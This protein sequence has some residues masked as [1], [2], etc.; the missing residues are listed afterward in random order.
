MN[1]DISRFVEKLER[2]NAVGYEADSGITRLALTD[3]DFKAREI[4]LNYLETLGLEV[5]LD[6]VGNIIARKNGTDASLPSVLVGS[7]L[8]TVPGGGAYDGT[9]GV[10]AA[11][12]AVEMLIDNRVEHEHPI[13]IIVFSIEESSRF[14]ISTVGSKIIT[15]RLKLEELQFYKDKQGQSIYDALSERGLMRQKM[16]LVTPETVKAFVELHIEQGPILERKNRDVGIVEAIAAP[17]RMRIKL[18]GEEAHSGSC[19]MDMRRDALTT[20][21]KIIIEV[22]KKGREESQYK[23]VATVGNC[24][25]YPGAMNVVPGQAVISIDIRGVDTHS[26]LRTFNYITEQTKC[27]CDRENTDYT[28]EIISQE[29]P[30]ILDKEVQYKIQQECESLGLSYEFMLSGAGH[31]TMN[32][33]KIVPSALIFI[34]CIK[35]ISHNKNEAVNQHDLENGLKILYK[36]LARLAKKNA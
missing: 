4:V 13:E 35:G 18:I 3:A 7:H 19:P 2:V 16:S 33:A 21:S 29:K 24:E 17:S 30:V 22:E 32:L 12:E 20:A 23:T 6:Q 27:I 36:T 1:V 26:I 11:I 28:I 8:D 25:V 15:N 34:P 9:L 14:N 10:I 5:R 31:D